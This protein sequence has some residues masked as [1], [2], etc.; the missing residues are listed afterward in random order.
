MASSGAEGVGGPGGSRAC[1]HVLRAWAFK[2]ES[3]AGKPVGGR[4]VSSGVAAELGK[5][6]RNLSAATTLVVGDD[7]LPATA[8]LV[9]TARAAGVGDPAQLRGRVP[10]RGSRVWSGE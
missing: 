4:E 1:L 5:R 7:D 10:R 6:G 9:G 2:V 3:A 8:P